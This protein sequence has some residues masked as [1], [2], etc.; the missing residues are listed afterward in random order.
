MFLTMFLLRVTKGNCGLTDKQKSRRSCYICMYEDVERVKKNKPDK[1][2]S[3]Y[4]DGETKGLAR[5]NIYLEKDA[6]S[7]ARR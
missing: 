1:G 3:P 6:A 4:G 2:S 7:F 5:N